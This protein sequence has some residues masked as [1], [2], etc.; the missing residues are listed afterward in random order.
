MKK[1][2][3]FILM[4]LLSACV[5]SYQINSNQNTVI[6]GSNLPKSLVK[7]FQKRINSNGYLEFEVILRSTFAKDVIYKVDWL[8]KD[9]F[10]LRDVLNEDY[11]AL[12]IP[13]GQEVILRKLASDTRAND[14]RLEIKA[15]N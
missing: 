7:Q 8:D 15:K 4:F 14:F 13:A 11:Q 1:N 9:G 10:V 3:L 5:P 6:L 12:R 2:I